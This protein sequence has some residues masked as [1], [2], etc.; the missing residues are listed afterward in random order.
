MV[1]RLP[2]QGAQRGGGHAGPPPQASA[3]PPLLFAASC[4]APHCLFPHAFQAT[5]STTPL[6]GKNAERQPSCPT[7]RPL[8]LRQQAHTGSAGAPAP[9]QPSTAA[10]RHGCPQPPALANTQQ[11]HMA[12]A[13]KSPQAEAS[14]IAS[15]QRIRWQRPPTA[16]RARPPARPLPNSHSPLEHRAD[17]R[18]TDHPSPICRREFAGHHGARL[19]GGSPAAAAGQARRLWGL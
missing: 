5:A 15:P 13:P 10:A 4:T 3:P 6:L 1:G 17:A 2:G 7:L 9:P 16:R 11:A 18:H 8:P 19:S 12:A 14:R